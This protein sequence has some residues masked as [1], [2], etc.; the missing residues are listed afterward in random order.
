MGYDLTIHV[1]EVDIYGDPPTE[2]NPA[3][4]RI[5][6][7]VDLC[8]V[9]DG[10]YTDMYNSRKLGVPV[11]FYPDGDTQTTEDMYGDK[12][13]AVPAIE[14]LNHLKKTFD[15]DDPYRRYEMA[16]AMLEVVVKRFDSP[17]VMQFG[18]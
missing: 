14:V 6:G 7:T 16:I 3:Y 17:Y 18:H 9:D 4:F 15:A 12:L 1:G 11:Y 2:K 8:K 10:F 5:I 13:T